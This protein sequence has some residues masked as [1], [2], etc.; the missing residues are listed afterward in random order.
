MEMGGDNFKNW[1]SGTPTIGLQS[2]Y[3]NKHRF[4]TYVD[5]S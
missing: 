3:T 1:K 5:E 4:E 2:V